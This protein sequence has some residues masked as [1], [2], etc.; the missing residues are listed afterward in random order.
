MGRPGRHFHFNFHFSW[1]FWYHL[2]ARRDQHFQSQTYLTTLLSSSIST[3]Y[4]RGNSKSAVSNTG[5]LGQ[6]NKTQWALRVCTVTYD[7]LWDF[8]NFIT[9]ESTPS[10][11]HTNNGSTS[12]G[13]EQQVHALHLT[14][15][16]CSG[17]TLQSAGTTLRWFGQITLTLRDFMHHWI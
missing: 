9:R 10:D 4:P 6:C 1:L 3:T 12:D 5:Q 11:F 15:L 13:S 14:P 16:L 2:W 7:Q 8:A 17:L